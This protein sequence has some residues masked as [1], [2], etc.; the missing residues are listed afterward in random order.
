[1]RLNLRW[2][3]LVI[4]IVEGCSNESDNSYTE[5][6]ADFDFSL[7]YGVHG[8]KEINTFNHFIVKDLVSKGTVQASLTLTEQE[9]ND[10]YNE[11]MNANIMDDLDLGKEKECFV[12]PSSTSIL[13]I[14][15][16]GEAKKF[17][18]QS[19]C[20]TPKDVLKLYQLEDFI[21]QI[22][23]QREEYKRLPATN[24]SYK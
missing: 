13:E 9:M 1:M 17:R 24:D 10:I 8:K 15:M 3:V 16:N 12:S 5:M 2:I 18:Y 21:E 14:H 11:M 6:P 19:Y 7:K 20:D 4:M 23:M 22:I